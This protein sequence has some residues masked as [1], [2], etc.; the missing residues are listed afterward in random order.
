MDGWVVRF[1]SFLGLGDGEFHMQRFN[2]WIV[3]FQS[4][5]RLSARFT[6]ARS[7]RRALQSD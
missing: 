3:L 6:V 1:A 4:V 2:A 7:A 5:A